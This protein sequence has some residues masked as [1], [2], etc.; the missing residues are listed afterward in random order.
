VILS[1]YD[2]DALAFAQ[3]NAAGN[4]LVHVRTRHIDWRRTYPELRAAR[5]LAADVLYEARNLEPVARFIAAHLNPG[6]FALLAD[7]KRSTAD[8][9]PRIAPTYGLTVTTAAAQR[10][11]LEGAG[12]VRG[13]L[14]TC[15][16]QC[17]ES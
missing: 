2:E 9:F 13:R 10:A 15:T 3:A 17:P 11:G 16:P 7:A 6:G 12:G 5:I 4:G 1:D 14:F 8:A